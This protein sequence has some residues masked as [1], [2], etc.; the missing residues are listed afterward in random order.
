MKDGLA[1]KVVKNRLTT[2]ESQSVTTCNRLKLPA[3]RRPRKNTGTA[4]GNANPPA[5]PRSEHALYERIR[6]LI[7]AARQTIARGVDV[8]QVWTSFEIGRHIVEHEQ[9]RTPILQPVTAKSEATPK[10]QSATAKSPDSQIIPS[11]AGK[12]QLYLPSNDELRQKLQEWAGEMA[13]A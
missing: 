13:H 4:P 8:V 3:A 12:S 11:S 9:K 5:V 10:M 1:I 6:D 2:E 7:I